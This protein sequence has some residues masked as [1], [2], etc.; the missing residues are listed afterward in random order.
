MFQLDSWFFV[1]CHGQCLIHCVRVL[2]S[3]DWNP[4]GLYKSIWESGMCY[5]PEQKDC[6]SEEQMQKLRLCEQA[7]GY[8]FEDGEDACPLWQFEIEGLE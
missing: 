2:Q 1:M 4:R 3:E 5:F 7:G 8:L 6:F